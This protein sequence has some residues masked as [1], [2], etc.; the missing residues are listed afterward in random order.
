[1]TNQ[2]IPTIPKNVSGS[3]MRSL[4]DSPTQNVFP[5]P[6][7]LRPSLVGTHYMVSAGHPIA[8][9]VAALVL[10]QGGN[11]IDAGVAAGLA[12]N[13]VQVDMANFGGIAPILVRTARSSQVWSINGVGTWSKSASLES[14]VSRFGDD[15]PPQAAAI[16]PGAP[17]AWI[18]ALRRFGTWSF[19]DVAAAAIELARNGFALDTRTASYLRI[20]GE[21]FVAWKTSFDTYWPLGKPPQ[22]G[23][24]LY[25]PKLA[26]LIQHLVD[27]EQGQNRDV[28]LQNVH[29]AFYQGEVARKIVKFVQDNGG[30]MTLDDLAE[31]KAEVILATGMAYGD[32]WVYTTGTWSQGP[33][34]LQSLAILE[35]IDLKR[36]GHNSADYIHYLVEAE[37]LAFNDRDKYYGDPN[38]IHLDIDWLLSRKHAEDLRSHIQRDTINGQPGINQKKSKKRSDTTYLCVIDRWGNTFSASPSDTLDGAPISP[39]LG[40]LISPRGVQSRL[41]PNHPNCMQPG[42][43]PRITPAP[44]IALRNAGGID[45]MI[46]AFGCPG[47][48]MIMQAMLQVFLNYVLFEM[49]PQ[50]SVEAPRVATFSF[51]NSFYPFDAFP[52]WLSIESRIPER[53]REELSQRGHI[54]HTWPD[55]EFDAGGVSMTLDLLPPTEVGRVLTGAA[56]PRRINYAIGR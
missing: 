6:D 38:F 36:F 33:V 27:A 22:V 44:A 8:A 14:M 11:A 23:D 25:Q 3:G 39:E 10:E 45:K 29:K 5:V 41:E 48:D 53:V 52:N 30:W 47:G 50:K 15:M 21:G 42:K 17:A 32:Y 19:K 13:V 2:N 20:L 46:W 40:I 26:A 49:T 7:S 1:M 24:I 31:Y 34:L 51:A 9:Q 56:D 28:A 12:T 43:R 55:F 18:E 4:P 16:I 35:G 54:I 37:K